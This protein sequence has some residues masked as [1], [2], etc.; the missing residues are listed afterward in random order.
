VAWTYGKL[1]RALRAGGG[2]IGANDTWI[3]ATALS[4][5]LPLVTRNARHFQR[6]PGLTVLSNGA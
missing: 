5:S 4:H 3:A 1:S 6:I 2:A